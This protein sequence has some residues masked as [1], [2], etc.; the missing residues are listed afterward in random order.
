MPGFVL[1][2]FLTMAVVFVDADKV[3]Q[4]G[5]AMRD[6]CFDTADFFFQVADALF[7]LL[8]LDRIQTFGLAARGGLFP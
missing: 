2:E 5:L 7:H 6:G 3:L 4:D 1:V 8:A